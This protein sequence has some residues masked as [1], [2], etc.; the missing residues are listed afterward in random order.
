MFAHAFHRDRR[1]CLALTPGT[2]LS[3]RGRLGEGVLCQGGR[4]L[5]SQC[6]VLEDFDLRSGM[7]IAI[8]TPGRIVIEAIEPSVVCLVV[9]EKEL[10]QSVQVALS[11]QGGAHMLGRYFKQILTLCRQQGRL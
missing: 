4:I 7:R 3:I 2:V 11:A 5:L 1:R 6:N 10:H 8:Q 9:A